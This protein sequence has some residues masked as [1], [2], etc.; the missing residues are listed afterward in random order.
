M[1]ILL[2]VLCKPRPSLFYRFWFCLVLWKTRVCIL[3]YPC[4]LVCCLGITINCIALCVVFHHIL[5]HP[6]WCPNSDYTILW[7]HSAFILPVV[8]HTVAE[9][10]L[11]SFIHFPVHGHVDTF[12][13]RALK[14]SDT[15]N[16]PMPGIR[17]ICFAVSEGAKEVKAV[18]D[19]F[20]GH[21]L[22]EYSVE[23]NYFQRM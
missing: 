13:F 4:F 2:S 20:L 14:S 23:Q 7:S 16:I 15:R 5:S 21:R 10:L 19:L 12:H 22:A 11:G 3:E 17:A 1:A 8:A 9:P 6:T 18:S